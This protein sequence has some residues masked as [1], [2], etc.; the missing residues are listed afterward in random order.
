MLVGCTLLTTRGSI[1]QAQTP[2]P[3]P[4]GAPIV[5]FDIAGEAVDAQADFFRNVFGWRARSDGNLS[6]TVTAPLGGVLRKG[7]AETMIYIGVDD[8]TATLEKVVEHGGRIDQ[9]RFEVPGTVVL[10]IFFDPAGNRLG[11]VEM[12]GGRARIP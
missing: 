10:G 12:E 11:L 3:E 8:V 4:A 7:F 2:S 6:V 9:P 5:F 1:L